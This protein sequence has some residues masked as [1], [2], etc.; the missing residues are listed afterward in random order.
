M[1]TRF[2]SVAVKRCCLLVVI[3][4]SAGLLSCS[5]RGLSEDSS[6]ALSQGLGSAVS[7]GT[8]WADIP[9]ATHWVDMAGT[10]ARMLLGLNAD[11]GG[12][13]TALYLIN[14]DYPTTAIAVL[15]GRSATGAG[16]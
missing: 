13:G 1:C 6:G 14:Q 8:P 9:P 4:L 15:E 11:F 10:S 3:L 12:I 16:F 7:C 5:R 2:S